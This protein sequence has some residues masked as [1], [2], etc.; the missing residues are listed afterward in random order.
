VAVLDPVNTTWGDLLSEALKISGRL[1]IGQTALAEDATLAWTYG[2][3]MLQE[4]ERQRWRVFRLVS[5]SLLSTGATSYTVGPAGD[6]STGTSANSVRP[7]KIESAFLRMQN[8]GSDPV[9]YPLEVLSSRQDYDRIAL[10]SMSTISSYVWYDPSFPLG[11][12]YFWPV[13]PSAQ[14]TMFISILE[15]LP[16][17]F[18]TQAV[19]I[20]LPFEY[21]I[22]IVSNLAMRLRARFGIRTYPGDVLPG[23]A[24]SSLRTLMNSNVAIPEL[25]MPRD[26]PGVTGGSG[27]NIFSDGY[28]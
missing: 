10:K 22:A 19:V 4:W 17:K 14:Y 18:L 13:P 9:D 11:T 8:V 15:Q 20:V 26:L 25:V 2:Q 12:V 3:W 27:Y 6:F 5:L 16:V 24:K 28:N 7:A 1:G 21:Y 23:Q